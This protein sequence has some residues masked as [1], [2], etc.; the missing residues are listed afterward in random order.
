LAEGVPADRDVLLLFA[1]THD[2]QRHNEFS[3]PEHGERAAQ[4]IRRLADEGRLALTAEQ[5]DRLLTALRD[6]DR[7]ET[8]DDVTVGACWDADRLTLWRVGITPDHRFL[9][10]GP[11]RQ[12]DLDFVGFGHEIVH[13][14]DLDWKNIVQAYSVGSATDRVG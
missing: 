7:G 9:S 12:V 1:A 13:G 4:L 10:T 5:L 11:A 8:T 2:T 14:P 3:D 6:H